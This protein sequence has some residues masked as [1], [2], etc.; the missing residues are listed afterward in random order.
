MAVEGADTNT[1]GLECPCHS[2]ETRLGA[3]CEHLVRQAT[4]L[5]TAKTGVTSKG[6]EKQQ[7]FCWK[8]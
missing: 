3:R 5:L 8:E 1:R 4:K 7:K 2:E 6:S